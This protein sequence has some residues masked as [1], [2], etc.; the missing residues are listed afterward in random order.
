M[1]TTPQDASRLIAE[2]QALLAGQQLA[3]DDVPAYI[4]RYLSGAAPANA[5]AVAPPPAP[6]PRERGPGGDSG[7]PEYRR[8]A[9]DALRGSAPGVL[10]SAEALSQTPPPDVQTETAW[11]SDPRSMSW[12]ERNDNLV[13]G[14]L[15]GFLTGGPVGALSGGLFGTLRDTVDNRFGG[16]GGALRALTGTESPTERAIRRARANNYWGGDPDPRN[17]PV[18]TNRDYAPRRRPSRSGRGVSRSR[19]RSAELSDYADEL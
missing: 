5:A 2:V 1:A 7:A 19:S 11:A 6:A 10:A 12:R 16:L 14:A 8:A 4:H 17:S 3:P 18:D 15:S 9:L 13:R